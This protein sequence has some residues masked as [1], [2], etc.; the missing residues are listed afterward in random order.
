M[1]HA[2]GTLRASYGHCPWNCSARSYRKSW[3]LAPVTPTLIARYWLR[4]RWMAGSIELNWSRR[5]SRHCSMVCS[6]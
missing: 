5:F 1:T 3:V 6:L 2:K 4:K